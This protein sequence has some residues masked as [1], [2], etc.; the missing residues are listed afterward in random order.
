[1]HEYKLVDEREGYKLSRVDTQ[2]GYKHVS[3]NGSKW[4]VDYR[5]KKSG[6]NFEDPADAAVLA[7]KY[8]EAVKAG[9]DPDGNG[10]IDTVVAAYLGSLGKAGDDLSTTGG[11]VSAMLDAL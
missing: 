5:G 8:L 10:K 6:E 11:I 9:H 2:S 3:A 1:M 7:A 4:R